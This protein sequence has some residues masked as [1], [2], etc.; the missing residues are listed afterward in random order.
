MTIEERLYECGLMYARIHP[1]KREA[2]RRELDSIEEAL[3]DLN[4]RVDRWMQ[5][6]ERNAVEDGEG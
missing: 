2:A 5:A 6:A 4:R 3:A 1:V